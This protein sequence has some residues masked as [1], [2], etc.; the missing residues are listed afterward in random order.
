VSDVKSCLLSYDTTKRLKLISIINAIEDPRSNV[1]NKIVHDFD[2]IF[3]GLGKLKDFQLQL[4]IDDTV[5][6][7]HQ[8]HRRVPFSKRPQVE[9]ATKQLYEDDIC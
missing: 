6:P 3:H 7:V 8:K 5:E 2:S 4:N 9:A 1:T